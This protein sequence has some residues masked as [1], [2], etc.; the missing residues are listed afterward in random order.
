MDI[1]PQALDSLQHGL[2]CYGR[3]QFPEALVQFEQAAACCP[4]WPEA[5]NNCGAVHNLL[6][7]QRAALAA[8]DRALQLRPAYAEAWNNRGVALRNLGDF[9]TACAAFA[10]ALV[11]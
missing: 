4:T 1:P 11:L 3:R 6:G 9:D 5:W 2:A 8:F 7:Q 10:Q